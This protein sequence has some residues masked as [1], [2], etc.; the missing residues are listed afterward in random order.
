MCIIEDDEC[1]AKAF[2]AVVGV[3]V[4]H[5]RVDGAY[6]D[7]RSSDRG[8]EDVERCELGRGPKL[9]GR[10]GST[11][12]L[13]RPRPLATSHARGSFFLDVPRFFGGVAG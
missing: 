1:G 4:P 9:L 12:F 7:G 10:G 11:R 6:G 2:R 3:V 13:D 8:V 5:F